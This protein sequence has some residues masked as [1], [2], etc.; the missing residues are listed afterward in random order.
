[1][2]GYTVEELLRIPVY[3]T[4]APDDVDMVKEYSDKRLEVSDIHIEVVNGGDYVQFN[5]HVKGVGMN[6]GDIPKLFK[7]FPGILLDGN[8]LGT[9]LGLSICKGI[10]DLHGGQI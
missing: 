4:I 6:H 5:I 1:M 10:I 7:S 2:L 3:S 9:G 8:V